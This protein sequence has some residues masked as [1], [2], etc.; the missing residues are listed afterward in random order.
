[1]TP[2]KTGLMAKLKRFME[3]LSDRYHRVL[4]IIDEALASEDFK[5]KKWAVDLILKGAE[6]PD[7]P[8][9]VKSQARPALPATESEPDPALLSEEELI[10][11]IRARLEA[12]EVPDDGA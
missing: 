12:P 7:K 6:T 11:H 8:S 10:R 3:A 5:E 2:R 1:M 9:R 4:Q